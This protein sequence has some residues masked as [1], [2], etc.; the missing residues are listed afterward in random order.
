MGNLQMAMDEMESLMAILEGEEEIVV[1]DGAESY[2]S[3]SPARGGVR[4]GVLFRKRSAAEE[5]GRRWWLVLTSIGPSDYLERTRGNP[6]PR[7]RR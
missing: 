3:T 5:Y 2:P 4:G 6:A 7:E 1:E